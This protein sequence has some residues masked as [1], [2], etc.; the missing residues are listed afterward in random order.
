MRFTYI[1][2]GGVRV[3]VGGH[4]GFGD[5]QMG[6][7]LVKR[8]IAKDAEEIRRVLQMCDHFSSRFIRHKIKR[9]VVK[10]Y[11]TRIRLVC[12][13]VQR[14]RIVARWPDIF[15]NGGKTVVFGVAVNHGGALHAVEGVSGDKNDFLYSLVGHWFSPSLVGWMGSR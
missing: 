5:T 11:D 1:G 6:R 9:V 8:I 13:G 7:K 12:N 3:V 10:T 4:V 15:N 2:D 14:V